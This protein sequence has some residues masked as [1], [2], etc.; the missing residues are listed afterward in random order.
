MMIT[1]WIFDDLDK[2]TQKKCAKKNAQMPK[3]E[4]Q[5]LTRFPV[6]TCRHAGWRKRK[7]RE[8]MMIIRNFDYK[9]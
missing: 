7:E 4:Q 2:Y 3:W 9:R 1:S 6:L 8:P 5:Q